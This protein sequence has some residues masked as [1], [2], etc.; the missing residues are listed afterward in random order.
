MY[1]SVLYIIY[2]NNIRKKTPVIEYFSQ[3]VFINFISLHLF[4]LS[5]T[6][7]IFLFRIE[8]VDTKMDNFIDEDEV[9]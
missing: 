4:L 1:C 2:N 3:C 6:V 9:R 8:F 5:R 7:E